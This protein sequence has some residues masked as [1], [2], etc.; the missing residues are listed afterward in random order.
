MTSTSTGEN[1]NEAMDE[2][3]ARD[4]HKHGLET[5]GEYEHELE[6]N[7]D[8]NEHEARAWYVAGDEYEAWTGTSTKEG[9]V[10]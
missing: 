9:T 1:K 4:V 3:V 6:R 10:M 2:H 5:R 7:T 8:G